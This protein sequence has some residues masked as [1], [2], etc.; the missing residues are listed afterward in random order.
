M[1]L[2]NYFEQIEFQYSRVRFAKKFRNTI[3]KSNYIKLILK[4]QVTHLKEM[5]LQQVMQFV[6]QM[7]KDMK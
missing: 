1:E 3:K 7:E 2:D 6:S 4:T 5:I